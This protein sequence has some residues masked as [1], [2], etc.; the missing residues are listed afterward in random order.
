M[1]ELRYQC[2]SQSITKSLPNLATLPPT[3]DAARLHSFRTYHQIQKWYGNEK[4]ATEWG[5]QQESKIGLLPIPMSQES[6]PLELLKLISCKCTKGCS[7]T[8]GCRKAGLVCS[9]LCKSCHGNSSSNAMEILSSDNENDDWMTDWYDFYTCNT[10][11]IRKI[12]FNYF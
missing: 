8:C 4:P 2:F 7:T 5:W 1:D 9:V 6:A 12:F 3:S 10:H 11:I